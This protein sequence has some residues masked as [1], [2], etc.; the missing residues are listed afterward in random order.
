M[1]S[2]VLLVDDEPEV[3]SSFQPILQTKYDIYTSDNPLDALTKV[4]TIGP[5]SVVVS[6]YRMPVMNGV[7]LLREIMKVNKNTTRILLTGFS[8]FNAI[9]DAINSGNIFKYLTKPIQIDHLINNIDDGVNQYNL[10]TA[11]KELLEKTLKGSIKLLM[12]L[13]SVTNPKSFTRVSRVKNIVRKL[14]QVLNYEPLWE[15]EIAVMLSE[16]GLVGV[17]SEIIEKKEK[18]LPLSPEELKLYENHP[19]IGAELLGNIPRLENISKAIEYLAISNYN[20]FSEDELEINKPLLLSQLISIAKIYDKITNAGLEHTDAINFLKRKKAFSP[21]IITLLDYE[22]N[23]ADI[24]KNA[25]VQSVMID[26]LKEDMI[27]VDDVVDNLGMILYA[28]GKEL[29]DM[30]IMRLRNMARSRKIIQ[31]IRVIKP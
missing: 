6:D 10:I 15:A 1:K 20:D 22:F 19:K 12:D 30:I 13:V 2:K 23:A 21:H 24:I 4:N 25:K 18:K 7:D 8:D 3:L 26:D 17:P 9:I 29:S 31:P 14:A 28:K 5:F 11:E 16:I 27:L